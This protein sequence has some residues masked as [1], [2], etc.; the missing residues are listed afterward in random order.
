MVAV[1]RTLALLGVLEVAAAVIHAQASEDAHRRTRHGLEPA[2]TGTTRFII[3]AA[4]DIA[5]HNAP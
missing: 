1:R 5:C 2:G 3:A 4:G